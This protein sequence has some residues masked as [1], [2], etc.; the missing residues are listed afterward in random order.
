A[1]Q[2]GPGY[3]ARMDWWQTLELAT[4]AFLPGIWLVFS[5]T[6]ARGNDR[7][8]LA[9]WRWVVTGAF[10]L[11]VALVALFGRHLVSA[12]PPAGDG[13]R[14]GLAW[15]ASGLVLQV[16]FLT[17]AVLVLIN[18]ERTYRAAVGTMRW[19][20]KFTVVGLGV[21]F[22]VRG[23]TSSQVVFSSSKAVDLALQH[24]NSGALL[25]SCML[26]ARSLF[27]A[28]HFA[29]DIY[30]SHRLLHNSLTALLAGAYLFTVGV[31]AKIITALGGDA[32]FTIKEF[33]VLVSLALFAM[34]LLSDR[35]RL[36]LRRVVSRHFKRPLHD[37]RAV[38]QNFTEGTVS[39]V[40]QGELC[41]SVA[42]LISDQFEVMAV[43]V[44]LVDDKKKRLRMAAS[45]ALSQA[46]GDELS[47][48]GP[49]V[50]ELI[51][52]LEREAEAVHLDE[53]KAP[54][55]AALRRCHPSESQGGNRVCMPLRARGELL[56]LITLGGRVGGMPFSLEDLDLLKCA[57]DQAAAGLLNLQLLARL[58][59]AKELEAFQTMSAFFVHDLKNTASKISLMLQNL[60]VHFNNPEFREDALRG[61]SETVDHLKRLISRLSSLRETL[62]L[63]PVETDLGELVSATLRRLDAGA[64]V[65]VVRSLR[66]LPKLWMDPEQMQKVVTNL[67]LNAKEA[68]GGAGTI[69]IATEQENGWAV[70]S[71]SDTGC[72]MSREFVNRSLFRPFQ[73]TKP[74]GTGIGLFQCRMIVEAHRGR[75]EVETELGKGTTVRVLLPLRQEGI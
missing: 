54:W 35:A 67:T 42:R 75:I 68:L 74:Q 18:L 64:G 25:I 50:T 73:T 34:L 31:F 69:G 32:A 12:V 51:R 30:P 55:G 20:I 48:T 61:V 23:Y 44:W 62:D 3:V 19:R 40:E 63:N 13:E 4:M 70:F 27:R 53:V 39:Q 5:L 9:K 10:A 14:W 28:G 24:L 37:Y 58:V 7:E 6:Y 57:A 15:G 26:I 16:I 41:S 46:K 38:W 1:Q 43:T 52:A 71:V 8:F 17:T 47:P 11:P 66:P 65:Q 45:T 56:G 29:V 21:L 59:Q 33:F 36:Q 2:L 49:E 72:G 22:A 60:P